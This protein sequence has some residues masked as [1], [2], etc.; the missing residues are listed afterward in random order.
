MNLCDDLPYSVEVNG[1]V[2][3]LTPA[4]DNVLQMYTQMD[5]LLDTEQA[6][7]MMYYLTDNAPLEM[8]ILLAVCEALFP[9]SKGE[10]GQKAFDFVQDADLIYAGFMQA[11]HIDLYEERGKMH[12]LKFLALFSGLPEDT[13]FREVVNIRL[14]PL[15]KP[16]KTNGEE[17]A[18]LVKAK[19]AVA[20]KVSEAERQRNL[21]KGLW[22]IKEA[23][24]QRAKG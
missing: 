6:E 8:E 20:L 11:Y 16:T 1:E 18:R 24:L 13:R 7:L 19:Q 12:W 22:G 3:K 14:R 10:E 2:Y 15:P 21:R 4:F 17:I 5:D 9:N 23:L